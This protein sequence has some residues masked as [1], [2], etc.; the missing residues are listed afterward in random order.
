MCFCPL[1]RFNDIVG[2]MGRH[3]FMT[4]LFGYLMNGISDAASQSLV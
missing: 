2:S 1:V 3:H 4:G